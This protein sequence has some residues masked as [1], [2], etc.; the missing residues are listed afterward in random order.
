M[1]PLPAI[2]PLIALVLLLALAPGWSPLPAAAASAAAQSSTSTAADTGF[3]ADFA[4]AEALYDDGQFAAALAASRALNSADGFALAARI[5]L[6]LIRYFM[7]GEER[8]AA[9]TA[10]LADAL[11]ALEINPDHLEGNLQA[12]I[13]IGYR[14]MLRRSIGDAR[15]GK[16]YIDNA[17]AHYPQNPWAEAALGGWNGEV[18]MEA[19]RFFAAALF[20]AGRKKAV[21]HF[22]AALEVEPENIGIRTSFAITLLRFNRQRFEDEAVQVLSGSVAMVAKNALDEILL[23]QSRELLQALELGQR[24][25]LEALLARATA[26]RDR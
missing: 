16:R 12:A 3:A 17:L 21:R 5:E 25:E 23:R 14:G 20:G 13:S 18:V 15:A 26:I 11:R 9:I 7:A 6:V 22:R 4:A 19:G 8:P 2:R 10:A 1:H 24:R